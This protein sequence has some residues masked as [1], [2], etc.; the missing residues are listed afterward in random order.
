MKQGFPGLQDGGSSS[1]A[2][3]GLLPE[4]SLASQINAVRCVLLL[5]LYGQYGHPH[6][7][8]GFA[9][10]FEACCGSCGILVN[11]KNHAACPSV[12]VT[13]TSGPIVFLPPKSSVCCTLTVRADR[14]G[15]EGNEHLYR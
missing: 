12:P 3:T 15:G 11:A 5:L 13:P 1:P 7:I 10:L 2:A 8:R 14:L 9:R 4:N 6:N